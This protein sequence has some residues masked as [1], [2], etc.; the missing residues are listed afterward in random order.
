MNGEWMESTKPITIVGR[1][2]GGKTTMARCLQ[3]QFGGPSLFFDID[4]EPAMGT[5]VRSIEELRQALARGADQICYRTPETV[6]EDPD[7]FEEVVRF[8]LEFGN[9]LRRQDAG[10]MMFTF[11]ELQDL[12]EEWV[13]VA[14][15][16]LRKRNIKPVALSQDPVSVPK[17]VRSIAE[18][19]CWISPPNGEME[20]FIKQS[21]YPLELLRQLEDFDMLVLDS[22]WNAVDRVR[23]PEVYAR[24]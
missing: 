17:R 5:E 19:N 14:M 9:E 21:G 18:W 16:R 15:K 13:K 7:E 11:D 24:E 10:P 2:G 1:S 3:D 20:D 22:A 6:V 4:E 8:L 23:A 12:D